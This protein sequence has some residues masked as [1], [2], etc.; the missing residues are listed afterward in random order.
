MLIL[1]YLKE[2]SSLKFPPSSSSDPARL[3]FLLPTREFAAEFVLELAP[4]VCF[5]L[6]FFETVFPLSR[7]CRRKSCILNA[8]VQ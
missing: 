7:A 2:V 5:D 4:E 3:T 6:A 1:A 8:G